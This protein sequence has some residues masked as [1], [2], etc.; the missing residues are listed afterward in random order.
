MQHCFVPLY[1]LY[2]DTNAKLLKKKKPG[3]LFKTSMKSS[4]DDKLE[5]IHPSP[6]TPP[7]ATSPVDSPKLNG[8]IS[9]TRNGKVANGGLN[10]HV[11]GA[12]IINTNSKQSDV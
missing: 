9:Y 6:I 3:A 11:N 5:L 4:V 12:F 7:M 10:G 8:S 2:E 1:P